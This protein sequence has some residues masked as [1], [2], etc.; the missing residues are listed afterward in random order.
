LAKNDDYNR[1]NTPE[2]WSEPS[3]SQEYDTAYM[4][5]PG[6]IKTA[7]NNGHRNV[8]FNNNNG[9]RNGSNG[10]RN[11]HSGT[12]KPKGRFG[13][14]MRAACLVLVCALASAAASYGVF[15][16][17]LLNGDFEQPGS[18]ASINVVEIGGNR[19]PDIGNLIPPTIISPSEGMPSEEIYKMAL[20]Q[21]VGIRTDVPSAGFFGQAD[22]TTPLS[23]SG[24]IISSDGYI[25]TNYHVVEIG[26]LNNLP[27]IV[28]LHEG[29]EFEATVI[30]FD[31]L[32]DVA[33]IKIETKD[34]SPAL[35]G[36]SDNI[37]VGQRIY[38]IGNP[39]G[40]LTYT[41]TD[42][43]VSAL[44]RIVTVDRNII[45]T[46]QL[47]AAVNSGNSGGPVYNAHG[48]VIGIVT[49]K[50]M[51][52]TV[53]GIGFAIPINDAIKIATELIE[54]GYISG[55]AFFGITPQTIGP[56][57][58]DF[59][60]LVAGVLVVNVFEGAAAE[61]AGILPGD[62]IIKIDDSEITTTETLRFALRRFSAGDTTTVDVWREGQTI[63][64]TITF[65]EDLQA[66]QPNRQ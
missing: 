28:S 26:H 27:I 33:L 49:A 25:L 57:H 65:D 37:R 31:S 44:D 62:I 60:D 5:S 53:E 3:Y 48:E 6:I 39:F 34:L 20:S 51:R 23:G 52:S 22:T 50:M 41:M 19:D 54:H 55:R 32:N 13:R 24:F 1:R 61:K 45:N 59:Y 38:A 40:E 14:F 21:V 43:I 2:S 10:Y 17:R 46:F 36:N 56:G 7:Q 47:S 42:G 11:G 4:Y 15:E 63:E 16:Y 58:A 18:S 12:Q 35:I 64:L 30:G 29:E 9:H 8:Y 66:G